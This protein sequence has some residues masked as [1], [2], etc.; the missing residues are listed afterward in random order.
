MFAT[1]VMSSA[2]DL[3]GKKP[4]DEWGTKLFQCDGVENE[5]WAFALCCTPCAAAKAKSVADESHPC[6]NFFCW[7]PIGVYSYVR[8]AYNI[9]GECGN[10]CMAG[11]FCMPCVARQAYTESGAR[12]ALRGRYGQSGKDWQTSLFACSCTELFYAMFCFM[13]ATH[14]TRELMQPGSDKCFDWFCVAPTSMYGTVRNTYGLTSECEGNPWVEDIAAGF[15][16]MPCALAR[17]QREAIYQK[18]NAATG[19]LGGGIAGKAMG[20]AAKYGAL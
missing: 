9:K 16:C 12:G 11:I 7:S 5:Q 18:A 20:A 19:G 4:T 15:F 1:K 10:D 14:T 2:Q 8:H 3:I 17:A 6:F 13:C